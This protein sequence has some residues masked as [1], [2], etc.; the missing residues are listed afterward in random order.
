MDS[1]S[2]QFHVKP[3][4]PNGDRFNVYGLNASGAGE[5]GKYLRNETEV[6]LVHEGEFDISCEHHG[7]SL[8]ATMRAG[9]IM[10]L[11]QGSIRNIAPRQEGFAYFVV[12]GDY[13]EA[14]QLIS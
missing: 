5:T 14:P 2:H 7:E 1:T 4:D 8:K 13:P 10:S 11:P 12:G 6:I 3:G 9:D